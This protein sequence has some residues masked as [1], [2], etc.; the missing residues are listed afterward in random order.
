MF[1]DEISG[2]LAKRPVGLSGI[3]PPTFGV[4]KLAS[5]RTG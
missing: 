4:L 1:L 2:K 3:I 5:T